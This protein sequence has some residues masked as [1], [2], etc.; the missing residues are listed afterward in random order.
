M[1]GI[2]LKKETKVA[3]PQALWNSPRSVRYIYTD[4][5]DNS[6][7]SSNANTCAFFGFKLG[8]YHRLRYPPE[9]GSADSQA[10]EFAVAEERLMS[11]PDYKNI[12]FLPPVLVLEKG[13]PVL[14]ETKMYREMVMTFWNKYVSYHGVSKKFLVKMTD[15][16]IAWMKPTQAIVDTYGLF[17]HEPTTQIHYAPWKTYSYR[18]YAQ[19]SMEGTMCSPIDE[20]VLPESAIVVPPV[21]TMS[22]EDK[23]KEIDRIIHLP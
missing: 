1:N 21:P 6:C 22:P 3:N 16:M 13:E 5:T 14:C 11:T 19:R 2:F 8:L 20:V 4:L 10:Q 7:L 18:S 12:T 9:S 23:L 17:Y 15:D